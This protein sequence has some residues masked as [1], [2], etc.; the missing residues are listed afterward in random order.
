VSNEMGEL[1]LHKAA[2][3]SPL[4]VVE[5]LVGRNESTLTIPD[6]MGE[7][8][9]H[10]AC[11]RNNKVVEYLITKNMASISTMNCRDQLPVHILSDASRKSKRLLRS[12]EY[13]DTI[14]KLLTA[15]PVV[16]ECGHKKV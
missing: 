8:P 4:K 9:L 1:P 7:L 10:E 15:Y 5:Y 6:E 11:V 12:V 3:Y 2:R 13:T 14:F 16:C